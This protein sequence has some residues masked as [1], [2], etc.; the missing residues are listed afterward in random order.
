MFNQTI[1]LYLSESSIDDILVILTAPSSRSLEVTSNQQL[2]YGSNTVVLQF[3]NGSLIEQV[4]NR[5]MVLYDQGSTS[6]ITHVGSAPTPLQGPGTLYY[7]SNSVFFSRSQGLTDFINTQ[8]AQFPYSGVLFEVSPETQ[9][10]MQVLRL[11]VQN[12]E[13]PPN[14]PRDVMQITGSTSLPVSNLQSVTYQSNTI[15]I[16]QGGQLIQSFPNINT[17]TTYTTVTGNIPINETFMGNANVGNTNN[18]RGFTGPGQLIVGN[19]RAF[20]TTDGGVIN[21]IQDSTVSQ[22]VNFMRVVDSNGV[23]TEL[24]LQDRL[25]MNQQMIQLINSVAIPLTG[26]TSYEIDG[27]DV[28]F[29]D[30]NNNEVIRATGRDRF[31]TYFNNQASSFGLPG[32]D[33]IQQIQGSTSGILYSNPDTGEVFYSNDQFL[34][35][36]IDQMLSQ[37]TDT[38]PE[39]ITTVQYS[40]NPQG[41]GS[42]LVNEMPV[43]TLN[44]AQIIDIGQTASIDYSNR[45]LTI[46]DGQMRR[47][48]SNID[49]SSSIAPPGTFLVFN[50][51]ADLSL[52]GPGRLYIIGPNAFFTNDNNLIRSNSE[53]VQNI[54]P[55]S[56]RTSS[57]TDTDGQTA[58]MLDIGGEPY[59][60]LSNGSLITT[61]SDEALLYA[62]NR[63]SFVRA[64]VRVPRGDTVTYNDNTISFGSSNITGIRNFAVLNGRLNVFE[65]TAPEVFPGGGDIYF[66]PVTGLAAYTITGD[67]SNTAASTID[68]RARTRP[69]IENITRLGVFDNNQFVMYEGRSPRMI[70]GG[71][72]LF[73]SGRTGFYSTDSTLNQ[74]L[75]QSSSRLNPVMP[76]FMNGLIDVVYNNVSIYEFNPGSA[77]R[78]ITLQNFDVFTYENGVLFNA[79]NPNIS[80][81]VSSVTNFNGINAEQF[82]RSP[83]ARNFTGPGTLLIDTQSGMAFFTNVPGTAN[84]IRETR[85]RVMNTFRPPVIERSPTPS[86]STKFPTAMAQFGQMVSVYEGARV[87]LECRVSVGNPRPTITFLRDGVPIDRNNTAYLI[88]NGNLTILSAMLGDAGRYTCRAQNDIGIDEASTNLTVRRGGELLCD[89]AFFPG[90][91]MVRFRLLTVCKNREEGRG[92]GGRGEKGGG[93]RRGEE[94]ED[95]DCHLYYTI[96]NHALQDCI[97]MLGALC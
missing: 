57:T 51:S 1:G 77:T 4:S 23:T 22:A 40:T 81:V 65:V 41:I 39:S 3:T 18:P 55:P 27:Q 35:Q 92:E 8:I 30:S 21:S 82:S 83:M 80:F 9:G 45:M 63:I 20:Y 95:I 49:Q 25:N 29:R 34:N 70:P 69:P 44:G 31:S 14:M 52:S 75:V 5:I 47:T 36:R 58:V 74:E 24:N 26:V 28:I 6:I 78:D 62:E 19:Q 97:M 11:T 68:A 90:L 60:T 76:S 88:E 15:S 13:N 61:D 66:N 2:Q 50:M 84:I 32:S 46:R 17:L 87:T 43:V 71:G 7:D 12:D 53:F 10:A 89:M 16:M 72:S 85:R 48:F 67:I 59:M 73:V 54:Q 33:G 37:V 91:P 86:V 56:I 96:I 38:P 94:G 79:M 93:E 64:P 42:L